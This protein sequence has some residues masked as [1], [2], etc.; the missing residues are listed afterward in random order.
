M[1]VRF[2]ACICGSVLAVALLTGC[3]ARQEAT[4][5]DA[6]DDAPSVASSALPDYSYPTTWTTDPLT[7]KYYD[8]VSLDEAGERLGVKIQLPEGTGHGTPTRV[9][10][11]KE[12]LDG[13]EVIVEY[14]DYLTVE[15]RD[16]GTPAEADFAVEE[17]FAGQSYLG[18]ARS[19]LAAGRS[20]HFVERLQV[21]PVE[22]DG[23]VKPGTGVYTSCA[24][25][26]VAE[27][28]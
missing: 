2:T 10:V 21:E 23:K 4:A 1:N 5:S 13:T 3:S 16:A 14:D 7:A 26:I 11:S 8:V 27:G 9:L 20:V 22:I 17:S 19:R 28:S 6:L 24:K 18:H 12:S 25:A 15:I